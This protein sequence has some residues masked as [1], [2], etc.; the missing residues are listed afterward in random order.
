MPENV[1]YRPAGHRLHCDTCWRGC[2][3]ALVSLPI[4]PAS[5]RSALCQP[6]GQDPGHGVGSGVGAGVGG[7]GKGV[8]G[9]GVGVG[10]GVGGGVG[11]REGSG[12]GL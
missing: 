10:T 4:S 5:L 7:E 3:G 6:G 9:G 1:W 8:G 2:A 12:V 11:A